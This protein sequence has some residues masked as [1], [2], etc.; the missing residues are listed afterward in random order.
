MDGG[1]DYD[2]QLEKAARELADAW[3]QAMYARNEVEHRK[4][5]DAAA[6]AVYAALEKYPP[7]GPAI[8]V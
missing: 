1:M 7:D 5:M 4:R 6:V 2:F 3:S 8:P